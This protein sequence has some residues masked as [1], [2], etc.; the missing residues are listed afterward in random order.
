MDSFK[1][2]CQINNYYAQLQ[3]MI[4]NHDINQGQNHRRKKKV[5]P[6]DITCLL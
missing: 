4:R 1:T 6:H 5:K 3:L 2:Y